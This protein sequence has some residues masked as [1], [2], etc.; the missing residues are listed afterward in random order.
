MFRFAVSAT[1]SLATVAGADLAGAQ[2]STAEQGAAQA[3]EGLR[4][5]EE[6]G[7]RQQ[8]GLAPHADALTP[9]AKGLRAPDLPD[10]QPCFPVD[11]IALTGP[12]ASRFPWLVA[13]T[14]PFAHRCIGTQAFDVSHFK[15]AEV[16]APGIDRGLADLVLLGRLGHRGAVCLAQDRHHLLFRESTL[17]HGLLG[18]WSH[19]L[20]ESMSRRNRAGQHV[21]GQ[22]VD[23]KGELEPHN[24]ARNPAFLER[25]HGIVRATGPSLP[26]LVEA[27]QRQVQGLVFVLDGRTSNPAEGVPPE[28]IV[29]GFQ[30]VDGQVVPGSYMPN[31]NYK[32]FT[33]RGF[34]QLDS[35][36]IERLIGGKQRA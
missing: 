30:A 18:G 19:L 16:L 29:G 28:D 3:Q 10:E 17:S 26:K 35:L 11:D 23:Y 32:L 25:L 6:R 5:Q 27:A 2:A 1:L 33:D 9:G 36:L 4:R 13:S 8:E 14:E 20:W 34:P 22:L 15:L 31:P 12:D 7:R 21:V 24:F